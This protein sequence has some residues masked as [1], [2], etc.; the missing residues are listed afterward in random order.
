MRTSSTCFLALVFL[1]S[2]II[3]F[4]RK[5]IRGSSRGGISNV[6]VGT[7][8]GGNV[9]D[10]EEVGA[11]GG[12]D[13]NDDEGD[14]PDGRGSSEM[15]MSSK[16]DFDDVDEEM[17]AA[18]AAVFSVPYTSAVRFVHGTNAKRENQPKDSQTI[19]SKG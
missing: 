12:K 3:R 7:D 9:D 4:V 6:L 13:E 2:F 5:P 18:A 14:E 10:E 17:D 19:E 15:A 1:P 11:G 8:D 16:G